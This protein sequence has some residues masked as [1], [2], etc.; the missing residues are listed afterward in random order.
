[1]NNNITKQWV[2]DF[3]GLN[4][5]ENFLGFTLYKGVLRI[6]LKDSVVPFNLDFMIFMEREHGIQNATVEF[7]LPLPECITPDGH[8]DYESLVKTFE[9][10]DEIVAW[11]ERI[12]V[13]DSQYLAEMH[14]RNLSCGGDL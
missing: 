3:L 5:D 6:S 10:P 13:Q 11:R 4:D 14:H 12:E 2:L 9:G 1:M 8:A 7:D